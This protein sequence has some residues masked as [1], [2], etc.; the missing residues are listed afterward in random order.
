MEAD[1]IDGKKE[2]KRLPVWAC[3]SLFIVVL[4]IFIG[5][6]G[7]LVSGGL[8]LVLGVEARHPG[9]VGYIFVEASMLLAVL[10]AAVILL[11][12]ERRPFSDLGL[13]LKG[14]ASGLWYGLLMAILL[15][16]LGF[17]ISV[18]LGEIE[19]TG[20]QFKPLDLL[21]SWVFFLLVALFEEILMRGYILGRLL[22]TNMNKFLALFISSAL[23]AF[24]HIFNPEIIVIGGG[25]SNETE[26]LIAPLRKKIK[27]KAMPMFAKDL[28]ITQAKLGNTAG[29]VGA[30]Y[31]FIHQ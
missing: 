24:M 8:S 17:G 16:L 20:F 22:H 23:F 19:V 11:R 28:E 12:L 29:M 31:H 1:N 18:V 10:T 3:I 27:E 5:L 13:S 7:T 25:V 9:V 6:Y 2:P 15:Y 4:F 30:V 26:Y 14:H 21:G